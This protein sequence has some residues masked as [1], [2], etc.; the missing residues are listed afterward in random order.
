MNSPLPPGVL[1][2]LPPGVAQGLAFAYITVQYW[3]AGVTTGTLGF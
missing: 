1:E 2:S 3:V